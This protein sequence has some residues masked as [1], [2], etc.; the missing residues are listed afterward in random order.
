M[1]VVPRKVWNKTRVQSRLG[2]TIA[3]EDPAE[4]FS[5]ESRLGRGG[6]GAVYSA[7]NLKTNERVAIKIISIED[8]EVIEDVRREV[9]ILSECD[10][11][12]IVKYQ[13]TYFKDE[14][15]WVRVYIIIMGGFITLFCVTRFRSKCSISVSLPR[16][17]NLCNAEII[18]KYY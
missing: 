17:L 13:G 8:D 18:T 9:N 7:M 4:L 5:L 16:V 11:S 14:N 6:F 15:L 12:H 3:S 10:N 1:S 2:H